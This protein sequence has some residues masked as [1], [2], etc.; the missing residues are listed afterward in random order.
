MPRGPRLDEP[1]V[2]HHVMAR[3]I[4]RE[5]IF[6]DDCDCDDLIARIAQQVASDALTIFAWALVVNHFH[7]LVRTSSRPLGRAMGSVLTGYAGRFNRRHG[8]T[9]HLFQNRFRSIV[10][11]TD[12]YFLELVRYIHLNPL[13][14][15]IVRTLEELDT[16]PYTGHSALMGFWP[17]SWQA[18]GEVF[19]QLGGEEEEALRRYRAFV[20]AEI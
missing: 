16:H 4:D 12:P 9:G 3:G 8:R 17:R 14:A 18:A 11:E 7:L 2:L 6:R 19:R 1:G 20:A 5:P 10:C 13:R 15:G